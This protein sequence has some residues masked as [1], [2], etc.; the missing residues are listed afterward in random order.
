MQEDQVQGKLD[1]IFKF[2]KQKM[3]AILFAEFLILQCYLICRANQ[4]FCVQIK[5]M[6]MYEG[7]N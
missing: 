6:S 5:L 3:D 2:Q 4:R 7:A 1:K